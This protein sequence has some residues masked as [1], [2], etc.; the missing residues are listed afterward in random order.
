MVECM[1]LEREINRISDIEGEVYINFIEKGQ[2]H[3]DTITGEY[4]LDENNWRFYC[5]IK[6]EEYEKISPDLNE[7][8]DYLSNIKITDIHLYNDKEVSAFVSKDNDFLVY[9]NNELIYIEKIDGLY[10]MFLD[11]KG[12]P[13]EEWNRLNNIIKQLFH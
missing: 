6:G 11:S 12:Q 2:P 13:F 8:I 10:Q 7:I 1:R 3:F 4:S 9:K 5:S